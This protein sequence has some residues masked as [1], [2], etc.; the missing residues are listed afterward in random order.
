MIT[1]IHIDEQTD[2]IH[3]YELTWKDFFDSEEEAEKALEDLKQREKDD[4]PL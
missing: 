3:V 4:R 2:K 1:K